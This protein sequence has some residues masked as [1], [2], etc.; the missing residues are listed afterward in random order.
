MNLRLRNRIEVSTRLSKSRRLL[1]CLR[2][3]RRHPPKR[4]P[5]SVGAKISVGYGELGFY[6]RRTPPARISFV[7]AFFAYGGA[8]K[9]GTAPK[10]LLRLF[11]G[12]ENYLG[13]RAGR[14]IKTCGWRG[15]ERS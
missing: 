12:T 7:A 14:K 10:A 5:N 13:H 9:R 2:G 15:E 3:R 6:R 8:S 4:A 11:S 1:R